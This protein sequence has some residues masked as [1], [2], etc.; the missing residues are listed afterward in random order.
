[1]PLGDSKYTTNINVEMNYWPAEITNLSELHEPM[2][3]MI[4]ELSE[5]GKATA[6]GMYGCR[7]WALHHNTDIGV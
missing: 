1:M 3:R 4:K 5:T 2:L 6:S 7:G